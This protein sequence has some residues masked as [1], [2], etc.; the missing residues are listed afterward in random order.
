MGWQNPV[1]MRRTAFGDLGASR[2]QPTHLLSGFGGWGVGFSIQDS[3]S[4]LWALSAR[5]HH[6]L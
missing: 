6:F 1:S 5:H 3:F 2:W 4:E